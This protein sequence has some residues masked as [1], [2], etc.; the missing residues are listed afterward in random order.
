V[1]HYIKSLFPLEVPKV[2][3]LNIGFEELKGNETIKETLKLLNEKKNDDFKFS[4]YI[5]GNQL[6]NG[7]V[8]VIVI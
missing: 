3:L 8:N 5:E 6:M 7:N 1:F 2:A 4:G